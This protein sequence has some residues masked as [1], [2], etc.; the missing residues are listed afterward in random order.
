MLTTALQHSRLELDGFTGV[1]GWSFSD[2]LSAGGDRDRDDFV[3]S[4]LHGQLQLVCTIGCLSD[5][6]LGCTEPIT[7]FFVSTLPPGSS[8]DYEA[9]STYR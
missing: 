6:G 5:S 2:A 8:R 1:A 7:F 4:R 9:L 3:S